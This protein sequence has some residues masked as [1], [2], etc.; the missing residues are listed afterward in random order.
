[1]LEAPVFL[2]EWCGNRAAP[3]W[4]NK[5]LFLRQRCSSSTARFLAAPHPDSRSTFLGIHPIPGLCKALETPSGDPKQRWDTDTE[6]ALSWCGSQHE[7]GAGHVATPMRKIDSPWATG[8]LTTFGKLGAQATA[9][10]GRERPSVLVRGTERERG[11]RGERRTLTAG[12]Y[13]TFS[14]ERG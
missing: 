1:M 14:S 13:F 8:A 5:R 6:A 9:R 7:A 2:R 3:V 11:A 4:M 12:F 10:K